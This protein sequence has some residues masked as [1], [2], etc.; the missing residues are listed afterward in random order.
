VVASHGE[1][2]NGVAERAVAVDGAAGGDVDRD[3]DMLDDDPLDRLLD[4]L[5]DDLFDRP[6]RKP[7]N[8][9]GCRRTAPIGK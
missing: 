3:V 8:G 6:F 5:L 2:R 4:D 7:P 9:R 1:V